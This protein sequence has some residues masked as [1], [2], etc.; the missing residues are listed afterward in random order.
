[1]SWRIRRGRGEKLYSG[2]TGAM[3]YTLRAILLKFI[4]GALSMTANASP[5]GALLSHKVDDIA[6][7]KEDLCQNPSKGGEVVNTP[8]TPLSTVLAGASLTPPLTLTDKARQHLLS[9]LNPLNPKPES[10]LRKLMTS[11]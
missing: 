10:S 3:T 5:C 7:G 4:F 1:M 9:P 8:S 6:G 11:A 2:Y